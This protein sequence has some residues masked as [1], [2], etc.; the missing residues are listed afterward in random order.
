GSW[1]EWAAADLSG[2]AGRRARGDRVDRSQDVGLAVRRLDAGPAG[3]LS[4][5]APEH[6]HETA[7]AGRGAPERRGA[8][9][10]A[11]DVGRRAGRSR[12]R[13]QKGALETLYV[14]PPEGS[15]V[16]CLDELGPESAKSVP[17]QQLVDVTTRPIAQPSVTVRCR[18]LGSSVQPVPV[19]S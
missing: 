18:P 7:S 3:H 17:G 5:R 14:G 16:V 15:V 19:Y 1:P 2:R 11:G 9:A 13:G 6:H 8:L 4:G 10:Q 12:V